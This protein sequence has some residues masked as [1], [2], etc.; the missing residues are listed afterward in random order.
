LNCE[1]TVQN[2]HPDCSIPA[3]VWE[4]WFETWLTQSGLG[5]PIATGYEL[6]LRLTDDDEIQALNSQYRQKDQPTDVLAFAAL[7]NGIPF[8]MDAS[9][10]LYLGDIIISVDTAQHQAL[11]YGHSLSD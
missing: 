11:D 1:I 9:I 8:V 4:I 5:L 2:L 10:P 7:E 6:S 3:A